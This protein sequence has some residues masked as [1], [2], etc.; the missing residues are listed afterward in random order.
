MNYLNNNKGIALV[1]VLLMLLVVGVLSGSLLLS[2]N[3]NIIQSS[4]QAEKTKAFYAAEAGANYLDS[5]INKNAKEKNIVFQPIMEA[6]LRNLTGD[7]DDEFFNDFNGYEYEDFNDPIFKYE[8]AENLE[9]NDFN[10]DFSFDENSLDRENEIYGFI[11][12]ASNDKMSERIRLTY[13]IQTLPPFFRSSRQA[14]KINITNSSFGSWWGGNFPANSFATAEKYYYDKWAEDKN[15]KKGDIIYYKGNHYIAKEDHRS[16]GGGLF[17]SGNRPSRWSDEWDSIELDIEEPDLRNFDKLDGAVDYG[18]NSLP[19]QPP[20]Q[21]WNKN[22]EYVKDEKVEHNGEFYISNID[23]PQTE[24]GATSNEWQKYHNYKKQV[25]EAFNDL[26][27]DNYGSVYSD[28]EDQYAYQNFLN[29]RS[30]NVGPYIKIDGDFIPN[31]G[32]IDKKDFSNIKS[33]ENGIIHILIDGDIDMSKAGVDF[34]DSFA[35]KN[36]IMYVNGDL[37]FTNNLIDIGDL[38]GQLA[39]FAPN[40]TVTYNN[41]DVIFASSMV[42]NELNI[43]NS[44]ISAVTYDTVDSPLIGMMNPKIAELSRSFAAQHGDGTVSQINPIQLSWEQIR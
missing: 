39:Y 41:T 33:D 43:N 31:S 28:S 44:R 17:S 16:N 30:N 15:Y 6:E 20:N 21:I 14:N 9:L 35:K 13:E 24:P 34:K 10:I 32:D 36:I 38:D 27:G 26:I 11:I 22:D 8:L 25:V 1:M 23:N 18:M 7:L 5:H 3:S 37:N 19:P 4:S 2:Y 12:E 29:D 40:A 42:V